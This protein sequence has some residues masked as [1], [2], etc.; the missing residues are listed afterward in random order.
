MRLRVK[1]WT[2]IRRQ[3]ATPAGYTES[4]PCDPKAH[5]ACPRLTSFRAFLSAPRA[6]SS[7]TTSTLPPALAACSAVTPPGPRAAASAPAA[8]SASASSN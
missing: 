4:T 2:N 1:R 7:R 5:P 8:S 3:D 6:A